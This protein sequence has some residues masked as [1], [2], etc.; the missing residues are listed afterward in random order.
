MSFSR[1]LGESCSLQ[2][3]PQQP[4]SAA[5]ESD[6]ELEELLRDTPEPGTPPVQYPAPGPLLTPGAAKITK[7]AS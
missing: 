1:N 4:V 5:S 7:E 6:L 3:T 2:T